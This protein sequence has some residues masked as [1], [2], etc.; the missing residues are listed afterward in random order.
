MRNSEAQR[1]ARWSAGVAILL[2]IIV[3][4][5]YL[6]GVWVARQAAKK[7]PPAV[8]A[9]VEQRS[10]EF[11][12]SKV[13]GQRTIYT[14]RASHTT[15]FKEGSRN[16]LEDVSITVYGK[17]GERN[18][19]LRT[20]AC[21][22]V[23]STGKIGCAGEVRI[24]LQAGG[25][26]PASANAVQVVTS[27]VSFDR[28]TGM[29][30]TDKQVTFRWPAGEGHALGVQYDSNDGTL[31]LDHN[32]EMTLTVSPPDHPPGGLQ[33]TDAPLARQSSALRRRRAEP[34]PVSG[35]LQGEPVPARGAAEAQEN[36]VHLTGDSMLFRRGARTVQILGA[37]HA[38]QTTRELTADS[39]LLEL[40]GSFHTRRLVASGHPQMR[41][42][43]VQG[44]MALDAD[45]ISA[46]LTPQGSVESIVANG[47]VHGS[48][49]TSA[50]EDAIG[51]GRV[52][53]ELATGLNVPRLL[54]AG[55]GVTLTS[56]SATPAGGT[57]RVESDDLELH[58]SKRSRPGQTLLETVDTLAPARVE[59]QNVVA[60]NGSAANGKPIKQTM[61]MR[62]HRMDLQFDGQNQLQQLASSGGVEVTRKL[63]DG[64]EQST[65]SRELTAKFSN[66]GE[67]STVDQTGDVRFHEG[68]RS[69]QSDRAHLGRDTNTATL[70]GSVILSDTTMRTTAHSATF[71]QGSNELRAD[72]NVLSTELHAGTGSVTNLAEA[73]AHVSSAHLVADVAR[74]HAVYSGGSR[75]WQGDSVIEADTVELDNPSHVLVANGHA[76]GVFPQ[77]PWTPKGGPPPGRSAHTGTELWHVRGG[78]LTYWGSDSRA[79]LE[80]GASAESAEGSIQANQIDLYF[81]PP[82]SASGAQQLSRAVATGDVSVRQEGRRGTSNRAEFTSSEGKF[83]LSEGK[84]TVYDSTGD[85]TTGRQLTFFFADDRIVV[86]SEEGSRTLSLHRIE[87]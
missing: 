28:E 32:V 83:V 44:P 4:A 23:S 47:N 77:S 79:R 37:V 7:A 80:Q 27:G 51:A 11:S 71:T 6:R 18:D 2:A 30:R 87:K 15:E 63:G 74:G 67:W 9:T 61:L 17:K 36:A 45:E 57:R 48:R 12:F 43:D 56:R 78:L 52:Q 31:H 53:V 82:G 54:T 34:P 21:D 70:T 49:N 66:T 35:G 13:E 76:R 73:P 68:P 8:P 26:A 5:E 72:G 46:A 65:A 20:R 3:A 38:L 25:G 64:P 84:P 58:F 14:V 69:G 81:S 29:A 50:G 39:L 19:T 33:V 40:D 42:S 41:E 75:L 10:N 59:W 16:L 55:G 22:F 1:Y 86:D 85:T 60:P 62:G 24:K